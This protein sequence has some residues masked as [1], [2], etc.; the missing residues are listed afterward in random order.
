M[1]Q[2]VIEKA[3]SVEVLKI[4]EVPSPRTKTGH[5]LIQVRA[6]GI[7]F[8]DILARKG[9]YPDA[10]PF[11]CVVGYEVAGVVKEIGE[12]VTGFR[13][14]DE[15]LAMTR[16]MG[17]AEEV[18]VPAN[19]VYPKP[20]RLTF[21]Q[22][23]CIPVN[24]ITAYQLMMVMGGL[25]EGETVLIHNAGGG[26]GLA[27]IDIAQHVGARS[28]GTC[29]SGKHAFVRER[30]LDHAIDYRTQDWVKQ[31]MAITRKQGV[32]LVLDPIGGAS[33]KKSYK[34]L[35]ATGRLGVFGVSS[36]A[37]GTGGK[38][39]GLLKMMTSMPL[40]NPL[41][42]MNKNVGVFGV[43]V[44]HLWDEVEKVAGWMEYILQGVEQ[45]WVRPHVDRIFPLE[46]VALA[47]T[48]IEARKNI[49]KVV[50]TNSFS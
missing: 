15:V 34:V 26:V 27:A 3:G 12:G 30:G 13:E 38:V 32:E 35:R 40:Y 43:N 47:H 8:A 20:A 7:N 46:D 23:A 4:K 33:W 36:L 10:P 17:Y 50:L 28:I 11:P 6:A 39:M 1:K 2:V 14:G 37:E 29:S 24:Y 21:E 45:G 22:A 18:L 5:V 19:Q 42:L 41:S 44:G 16:F 48:H 25:K 49:G 9:M 31:V